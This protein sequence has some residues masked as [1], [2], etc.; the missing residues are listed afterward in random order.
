MEVN[1]TQMSNSLFTYVSIS[2]TYKGPKANIPCEEED[3][4]TSAPSKALSVAEK[5]VDDILK[6]IPSIQYLH[7]YAWTDGSLYKWARSR[8]PLEIV[9]DAIR[10][11]F[12]ESRVK[13]AEITE[14]NPSDNPWKT[15][16]ATIRAYFEL[17]FP[18]SVVV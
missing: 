7:Q 9:K 1:V 6:T 5:T 14:T 4:S 2:F 3:G 12:K 8:Q 13:V 18:D 16:C 10:V 15:G 17:N 11:A